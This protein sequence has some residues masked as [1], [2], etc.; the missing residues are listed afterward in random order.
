MSEKPS[1]SEKLSSAE[2]SHEKPP[3][4]R[5]E[6]LTG[7]GA[8]VAASAWPRSVTAAGQDHSHGDGTHAEM[9]TEVPHHEALVEAALHCVRTGQDCLQHCFETFQ[10]GDTSLAVCAVK[11]HE[12][13]VSCEALAN[14][15]A[16]DSDHLEVIARA[17]MEV[18][19]A[20]ETECR[21]HAHHKPCIVCA[22][23]CTPC[24]D[25]CKKVLGE[26]A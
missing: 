10:H 2:P 14:F 5:R 17:A 15:A 12:L 4:S 21:K 8:A 23:S 13:A 20:C 9:T 11:V 3:V 7:V 1:M 16:H 25:E 22:D 26:T 24:I 6:V 18:C 19:A